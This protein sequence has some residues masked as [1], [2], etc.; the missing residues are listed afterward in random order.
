MFDG[1]NFEQAML[2]IACHDQYLKYKE[3]LVEEWFDIQQ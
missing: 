3:G 2:H 1:M